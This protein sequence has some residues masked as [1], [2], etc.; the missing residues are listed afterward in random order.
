MNH[1]LAVLQLTVWKSIDWA[2]V[3]KKRGTSI[4][5]HSI[6][7]HCNKERKKERKKVLSLLPSCPQSGVKGWLALIVVVAES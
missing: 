3:R 4:G 1:L 2:F 7:W 6:N 5:I